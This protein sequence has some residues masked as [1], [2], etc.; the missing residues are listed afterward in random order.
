MKTKT[1]KVR[2][3]FRNKNIDTVWRNTAGKSRQIAWK[4]TYF[5]VR[6]GSLKKAKS[7]AI[8]FFS[9]LL[10]EKITIFSKRNQVSVRGSVSRL[11]D[12]THNHRPVNLSAIW[13]NLATA[14]LAV[15]DQG[16][17]IIYT[18]ILVHVAS[19]MSI[20]KQNNTKTQ[21]PVTQLNH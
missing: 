2:R 21:Y 12:W 13:F 19:S 5:Y 18:L 20:T 15:Q 17:L 16:Y 10:V 4:V 11:V 3:K 1:R 8:S 9:P 6:E 7:Y 14:A